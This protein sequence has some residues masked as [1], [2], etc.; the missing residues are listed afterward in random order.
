MLKNAHQKYALFTC[1][2][3]RKYKHQQSFNRHLKQCDKYLSLEK[4]K[5][6]ISEFDPEKEELR[7]IVKELLNQNKNMILANKEMREMVD[8]IIPKIGN[9]NTTIHN[10]FNLN[11]NSHQILTNNWILTKIFFDYFF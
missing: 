4:S 7:E 2:C 10:K 11:I 8:G 5:K 6:Q 9:N 1:D 3:G